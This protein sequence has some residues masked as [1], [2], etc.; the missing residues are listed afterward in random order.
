[1]IT[2]LQRVTEAAVTVDGRCVGQIGKG[3]LLLIGVE[4]GDDAVDAAATAKKIAALRFFPGRTPMDLTLAEAGG[5]C[6]AVSQFTLAAAVRKGNRPGFSH[7]EDPTRADVLY[8]R[9]C[10][11]LT[12]LG[13]PVET[14]EFGAS[15]QVSLINDGPI[16]FLL[17]VR[18]GKVRDL[19]A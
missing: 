12:T 6:L 10:T 11:E 3:A 17:S 15:M 16:T 8:R 2:V 13:L 7:A 18:D 1:M 9:V 4:K 5:A 19:I 14:G